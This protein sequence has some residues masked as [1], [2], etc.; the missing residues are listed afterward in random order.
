VNRLWVDDERDPPEGWTW[1]R[2]E[3]EARALLQDRRWDVMSLDHDLGGL[4]DTRSLVRMM[5]EQPELWPAEVLV[6][7]QNVVGRRWLEGMVQRY[8][9]DPSH[10]KSPETSTK[11][12]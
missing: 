9:P 3:R 2:S 5:C 11:D 6:H 8:K 10:V 4:S 12:Q 7:S 1:A